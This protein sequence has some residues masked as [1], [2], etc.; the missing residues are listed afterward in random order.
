MHGKTFIHIQAQIQEMRS[1]GYTVP[2]IVH[3]LNLVHFVRELGSRPANSPT[4]GFDAES[5]IYADG[6]FIA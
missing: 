5:K 6:Q 2:E 3:I 4:Y 1:L